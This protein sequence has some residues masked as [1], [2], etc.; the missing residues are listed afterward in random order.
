M[1]RGRSPGDWRRSIYYHYYGFPA[2]HQVARH[3]GIRTDRYK[4]MWFY[5]F[6]EWEFY[7]LQADPDE[8]RNLYADPAQHDRI[9]KMKVDLESLRVSYGDDSA[10]GPMPAAWR[11][12]MRA[13]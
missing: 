10:T 7:D 3:Y 5:Q 2:V 4:L 13:R 9:A 6:D 12:R 1:L 8:L 11:A